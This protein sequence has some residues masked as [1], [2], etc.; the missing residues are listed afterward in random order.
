MTK[1]FINILI[2]IFLTILFLKSDYTK[3]FIKELRDTKTIENKD[4]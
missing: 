3:A 1:K 4:K 2:V